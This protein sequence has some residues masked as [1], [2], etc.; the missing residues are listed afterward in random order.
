MRL[1]IT[2]VGKKKTVMREEKARDVDTS[3]VAVLNWV[4]A[5]SY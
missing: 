2:L 1:D 5:G 4:S 3:K